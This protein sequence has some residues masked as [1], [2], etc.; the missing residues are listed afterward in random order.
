MSV[1]SNRSIT[2]A[3]SAAALIGGATIA[4]VASANDTKGKCFGINSCK[5]QSA[6]ASK[7]NECA[8][9]NQCKGKGWQELTD[10]KCAEK[11]GQFEAFDK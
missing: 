2:L 10:K 8:G 1:S 6:C 3:L 11:D 5:G 7:D 4:T 9:K